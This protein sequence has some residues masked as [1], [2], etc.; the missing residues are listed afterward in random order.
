MTAAEFLTWEPEDGLRWQ[1]IDG[2]AFAM[3]PPSRT[4]SELQAA[5]TIALGNHLAPSP[6]C[7]VLVTPGV[8]PKVSSANNVRVPDLAVICTRYTQEQAA[9]DNPVVVIELLSPSNKRATWS[10]IWAY[11]SIPSVRE[12]LVL[13]TTFIGAEILQL[14]P[15]RVWPGAPLVIGS[16]ILTLESIDFQI[17][18]SA[19]YAKTRLA[20][21]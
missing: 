19:L 8:V 14:G 11:T 20:A 21:G 16:G 10:N 5:L 1:L 6:N 9:I 12:I 2:E 7:S 3:A 13:H 4:H 15:D 17:E 18:L